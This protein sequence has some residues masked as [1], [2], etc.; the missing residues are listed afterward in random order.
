MRAELA[1]G[2]ELRFELDGNLWHTVE[3]Q[4]GGWGDE[5]AFGGRGRS[6]GER[7]GEHGGVAEAHRLVVGLGQGNVAMGSVLSAHHSLHEP[8]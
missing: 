8:G 2:R 3:H 5:F 1:V 7:R 4:A 6:R